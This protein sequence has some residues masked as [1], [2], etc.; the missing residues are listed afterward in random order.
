M[1][2]PLGSVELG[3]ETGIG[4]HSRLCRP[5]DNERARR[6]L[7]LEIRHKELFAFQRGDHQLA[8]NFS[9]SLGYLFKCPIASGFVRF[10]TAFPSFT[11]T[12]GSS[13]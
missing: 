10:S 1:L 12:Q 4:K 7:R 3:G 6:Q 8:Y 11:A 2:S 9:N 5:A 13:Q